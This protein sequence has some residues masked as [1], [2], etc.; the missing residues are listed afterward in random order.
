MAEKR[1][2]DRDDWLLIFDM[3]PQ[4]RCV[5]GYLVAVVTL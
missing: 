3:P 1:L 4:R 5:I 2:K